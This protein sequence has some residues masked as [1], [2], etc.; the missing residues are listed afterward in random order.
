M[1]AGLMR[2][3]IT[4]QTLGNS[5]NEFGEAE[6]KWLDVLEVRASINPISGREFISGMKE[7][8]EITH[9]ITIRY[10]KVIR[11]SMRVLFGERVFRIM[12][13]IDQWEMNHELTLMCKEIV[14]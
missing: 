1:E 10:N 11:P 2:H 7:N 6:D 8:S 14:T 12:H 5:R 3:K 13:I 9:K 4:V